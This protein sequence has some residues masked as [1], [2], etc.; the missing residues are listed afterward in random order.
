MRAYRSG[1]TIVEATSPGLEPARLA[2]DFVNGIDPGYR[3]PKERP[4]IRF[5]KRVSAKEPV[6]F[7]RNNPMFA[8]G[9]AAQHASGLAGDG[10]EST[11]W[12][13]APDD[14]QPSL[15]LDTEKGLSLKTIYLV[16]PEKANWKYRVETSLNGK[17]WNILTSCNGE[18]ATKTMTFECEKE[19]KAQFVRIA[20]DDSG[21]VAELSV[22]GIILD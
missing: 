22:T 18:T 20:F 16:F 8:S 9:S 14:R 17:T 15:M 1:H 21:A 11:W 6:V 10:D 4:Y 7:G 19:V 3:E 5:E 13:S 2:I 12:E